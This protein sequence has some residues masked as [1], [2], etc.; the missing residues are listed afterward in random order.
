[1]PLA[2]RYS[3]GI[4]GW[5]IRTGT[6]DGPPLVDLISEPSHGKENTLGLKSFRLLGVPALGF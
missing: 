5:R 2:A 6:I 3:A 1:M 4:A